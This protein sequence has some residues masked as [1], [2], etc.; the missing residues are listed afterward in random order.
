MLGDK[1]ESPDAVKLPVRLAIALLKDRKGEIHLSVP[2]EGDLD[3]PRFGI[4]KI[5]LNVFVN[6]I[7]KTM[8]SPFAL[9]GS[10][11]GG[12]GEELSYVEFDYGKSEITEHNAKKLD[13]LIRALYER[14]LLKLEIEGHVDTEE[15]RLPLRQSILAKKL[16]AQ[17]LSENTR[18]GIPSRPI[19][20]VQIHPE[21]YDEYLKMA[22]DKEEFPKPR[23]ERGNIK[24]LP[25]S[26]MEKLMLTHIAVDDDQLR[27]LAYQ[28]ASEVKD[29]ILSSGKVEPKRI[30]LSEPKSLAPKRIEE[31]R[32][33]RVD[34]NLK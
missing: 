28:R 25:P 31:L 9:I 34:L 2:V 17:K 8:S 14:P 20:E 11:F 29:Y 26:E 15:D 23:D 6:A 27:Q 19:E 18:R 33:S 30:F 16:K 12:G 7:K 22:Y 21:E 24:K 4:G 10:M 5:I 13:I 3:D 1:V 32:D